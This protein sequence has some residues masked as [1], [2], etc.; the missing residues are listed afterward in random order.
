MQ[1]AKIKSEKRFEWNN[2]KSLGVQSYG[3]HN[4]YP[5]KV[6]EVVRASGTGKI[7]VDI[8]SDFIGGRGF[9]DTNLYRMAVN[10]DNQTAD[11]ILRLIAQDYAL[12]NGF[13][14]HV[15]Y[16]MNYKVRE[17][18]HI[19]FEHVRFQSLD[20][21]NN[22]DKIALHPDWG[23]RFTHLRKWKKDDIDF[24]DFFDPDPAIVKMQVEIAGGWDKYKGQILYYSGDGDLVY[25]LPIYD[26]VLTDMRA[27]EGLSNITS[28]NVCSN[29]NLAG[30]LI[31][32]NNS[33]E[34][35]EETKEL[36]DNLL[37]YQGDEVT[38]NIAVASAKS[39]DEIPEF[40]KFTGENYDKA[41]TATEKA[42][43]ERIGRAFNQP[44]ILRAQ[45]VGSNFGADAIRNAY[46]YYNSIIE[47]ERMNLE[48]VFSRI[49]K[50][51]YIELSGDFSIAPLSYTPTN[52]ELS[53][54]PVEMLNTLTVN[55]KRAMIE[56]NPLRSQEDN[57]PLLA[58]KIGVGGTQSVI[59]II[60]NETMPD[61]RKRGAL[62]V[63][64]SLTDEEIGLMIPTKP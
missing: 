22:F 13:A 33:P 3:E 31:N 60:E 63:L 14:I 15:N 51:Y 21:N 8:Y 11:E 18:Y 54:I 45:D 38:S 2:N 28:R 35:E 41:Y 37:E 26:A 25:P 55:E 53:S 5:Q 43:P 44:P 19:P 56:Y 24:V 40:V 57:Q 52:R 49:F 42:L 64:F 30:L 10:S 61:D 23:K 29:F 4:D 12:Y 9:A 58:E 32:I 46:D 6:R 34:S 17:I 39:R 50:Y 20:E 48:R 36:Q 16:N 27:E 47:T 1:L 7:C 59:A 62:K